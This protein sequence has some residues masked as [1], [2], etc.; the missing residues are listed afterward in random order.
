MSV[1]R[2]LASLHWRYG[3]GILVS[4][5][6]L[7]LVMAT[8][9][10][11]CPPRDRYCSPFFRPI[12]GTSS[13][14]YALFFLAIVFSETARRIVSAPKRRQDFDEREFYAAALFFL[15]DAVIVFFFL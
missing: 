6:V 7:F 14:L 13:T 8:L 3:V 2:S 12:V 10:S 1:L 4:W 5:V 9:Q 11:A 15:A